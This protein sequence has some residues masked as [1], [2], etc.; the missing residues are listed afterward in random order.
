MRNVKGFTLIEL[1]IVMAVMAILMT[2]AIPSFRG[3]QQEAKRTKVLADL[4]TLRLAIESFYKSNDNSYPPAGTDTWENILITSTASANLIESPL[5]DAFA[6]DR[7]YG[8]ALSGSSP[9][10][11]NYYIIWSVGPNASASVPLIDDATGVVSCSDP[12]IIWNSSGQS[13]Y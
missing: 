11:S 9:S 7:Q 13:P 12:S 8:Y 10:T 5:M 1:L 6:P 3:M 2:I 4:R